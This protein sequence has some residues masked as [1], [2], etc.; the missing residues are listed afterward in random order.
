MLGAASLA[1]FSLLW[2]LLP[3]NA[4][5]SIFRRRRNRPGAFHALAGSVIALSI[6]PLVM[7]FLGFGSLEGNSQRAPIFWANCTRRSHRC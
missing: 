3:V 2:L 5:V 4:L 7:P 6:L 1:V